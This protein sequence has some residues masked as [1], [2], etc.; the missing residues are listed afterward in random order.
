MRE[1][2]DRL[3]EQRKKV[4]YFQ[5]S[6]PKTKQKPP[7]HHYFFDPSSHF[8]CNLHPKATNQKKKKKR[9]VIIIIKTLLSHHLSCISV[10][11]INNSLF[12]FSLF[13]SLSLLITYCLFTSFFHLKY[14][15]PIFFLFPY[16]LPFSLYSYSHIL[17]SLLFRVLS[18]LVSYQI[19]SMVVSC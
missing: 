16:I 14:N 15:P 19:T 12:F 1:R 4:L 10:I 11:L 8:L 3:M 5:K 13:P 2:K 7:S 9:E 18:C 6:E 17:F